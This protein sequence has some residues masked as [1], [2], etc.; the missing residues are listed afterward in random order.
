MNLTQH[1]VWKAVSGMQ[2]RWLT[3][4]AAGLLLTATGGCSLVPN[5]VDDEPALWRFT[6]PSLTSESGYA[7]K[8]VVLR[9]VETQAATLI[10]RRDMA[11]SR[12]PQSVAYYR[13]N[14]W[15]SSPAVMLDEVI[16][17]SLS[18]RP[19]VRNVV[20]G[21]AR[22]PAQLALY[23]KIGRLE[24]RLDGSASKVQ[25]SVACSW[26][27]GHERELVDTLRFDRSVALERNDAAHYAAAAQGLVAALLEALDRQGRALAAA[28]PDQSPGN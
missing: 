6:A 2:W 5:K 24:H 10:D 11:Y 26:Y 18:A 3:W 21:S 1:T 16:N 13:D 25:M 4:I 22:A 28:M 15:V 8:P 14:R 23:C 17:E 7:G 20:R 12:G 27:Q 19:W 9:L